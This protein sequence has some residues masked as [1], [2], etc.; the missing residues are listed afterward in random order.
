MDGARPI[1]SFATRNEEIAPLARGVENCILASFRLGLLGR[2]RDDTTARSRKKPRLAL[3]LD[4]A[5]VFTT[6]ESG[7]SRWPS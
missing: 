2:R 5:F 1:Q 7:N 3:L 6:S 4:G